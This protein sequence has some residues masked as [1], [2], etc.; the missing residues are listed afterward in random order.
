MITKRLR[1][2]SR[3]PKDSEQLQISKDSRV[4]E[5]QLNEKLITLVKSLQKLNLPMQPT[6]IYNI[7]LRA[8][9]QT[10]LRHAI[11]RIYQIAGNYAAEFTRREYYTTRID[12]ET[13]QRLTEDYTDV[14][15]SRLQRFSNFDNTQ[16]QGQGQEQNQEQKQKQIKPEFIVKMTTAT[17]TQDTMRQAIITKSQQVLNK[18]T[19]TTAAVGDTGNNIEP[20]VVYVWVTSQD[21]KVCPVCSA[22]EGQAWDYED[23]ANIPSIPDDTHPNCRCMLQLSEAES[24]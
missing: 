8:K 16:R 24:L 11:E 5:N 15:F 14:F 23:S 13:I 4:V 18:V 6:D 10:T 9:V 20:Q 19:L 2:L 1:L 21:D 3:I 22:Y 7:D 12:L 17:L